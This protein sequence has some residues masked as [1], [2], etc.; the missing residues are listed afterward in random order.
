M[1]S[2]AIGSVKGYD[3]IYPR[4][5]NLVTEKRLYATY[6]DPMSVGI[7]SVKAKLNRLHTD[8]ALQGYEEA[9]VHHENEVLI[10]KCNLRCMVGKWHQIL[11]RPNN[12][13]ILEFQVHHGA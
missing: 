8:M 3:E 13:Y 11:L 10:N 12:L 5:L 6:K 9:H 2:C 4:L 1:T 7:C